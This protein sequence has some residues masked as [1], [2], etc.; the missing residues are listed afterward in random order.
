MKTRIALSALMVGV[1]AVAGLG[2]TPAPVAKAG[3]Y[4]DFFDIAGLCD[5]RDALKACNADPEACSQYTPPPTT[6]YRSPSE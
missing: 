6:R 4:C 5:V 1:A 2:V 3:P